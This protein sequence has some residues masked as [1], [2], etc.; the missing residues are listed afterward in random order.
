MEFADSLRLWLLGN[1][2]WG[3]AL[4]LFAFG[5]SVGSFLN[6]VI[7]R[8]PYGLN[9]FS[10]LSTCPKCGHKIHSWENLPII[11]YIFLRGK[12]SS[13]HE[14]I[15]WR[16]PFVELLN[17]LL[18]GWV[19]YL[20]VGNDFPYYINIFILMVHLVFVSSLVVVTFIDFDHKIIPDE[21]SL[22]GGALLLLLS[23]LLPELHLV[24]IRTLWYPAT[25]AVESLLR[26]FIGAAVG[27][28]LLFIITSVGTFVM[29]ERIKKIQE[30]EDP[31]VDTAMGYGDVKLM[32]FAGALLGWQAVLIAFFIGNVCGATVGIIDK[33]RTGEDLSIEQEPLPPE[34]ILEWVLNGMLLIFPKP[35]RLNFM[36]RWQTG[37]SVLPLGP[38]LCIG[39]LAMFF[40]G[41]SINEW[42]ERLLSPAL[43][44]RV[45]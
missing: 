6:V 29:Q 8:L 38:Y 42:V 28:G 2:E 35:K 1:P 17:G 22:G 31:E 39:I 15:H 27:A 19:G 37:A 10:P 20:S 4:A 9:L 13:C 24:H 41:E 34:G 26:G 40:Y 23:G 12:C 11:S 32:G 5:A 33:F 21:I 25:P 44:G 14:P 18:W 16:Y 7:F 3:C 36:N 43:Q 45:F 30:T